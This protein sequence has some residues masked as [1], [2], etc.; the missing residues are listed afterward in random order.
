MKKPWKERHVYG[1][2]CAKCGHRRQS[3]RRARARK[4]V[5]RLCRPHKAVPDNQMSMFQDQDTEIAETLKDGC[6]LEYVK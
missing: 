1:F 6:K 2:T 5:C 4:E 3:F